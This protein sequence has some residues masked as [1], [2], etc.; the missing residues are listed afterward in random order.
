MLWM[1][2]SVSERSSIEVDFEAIEWRF[3]PL[4]PELEALDEQKSTDKGVESNCVIIFSYFFV[5]VK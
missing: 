5:L 2:V 4:L 1:S 3:S